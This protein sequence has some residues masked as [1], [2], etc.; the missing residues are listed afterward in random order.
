VLDVGCGAG[1]VALYLQS[2]G[3]DVIGI[4][5]SP[6]AVKVCRERGVKHAKLMP[7][8]QISQKLGV[9]DTV[10]MF[11]NNFGLFENFTRARWLLRKLHG[12]TSPKARILASTL[13]P[14]QTT[15]PSHLAY[16]RRNRTRGRTGGQARIRIRYKDYAT[17]WFDYWLVSKKELAAILK[18]T[19]WRAARFFDTAGGRYIAVVGKTGKS[20]S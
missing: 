16:H 12:M 7:L 14:Y 20:Q 4:D 15:E 17:P 5:N 18:G 6:L 8:T 19:G 9:F 11:G 2:R 13:D 1:R 3:L 10:V